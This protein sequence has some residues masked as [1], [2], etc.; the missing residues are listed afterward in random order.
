MEAV[1]QEPPYELTPPRPITVSGELIAYMT[2]ILL[3]FL[4]Y[5]ANLDVT[6]MSDV[7]ANRA[8]A[9]WQVVHP[10]TPGAQIPSESALTLWARAVPFSLF[11]GGEFSARIITVFGGLALVM[12]PLLFREQ[13]GRVQTFL[14]VVILAASP[15]LMTASRTGDPFIW[16]MLFTILTLWAFLRWWEKQQPADALLSGGFGAVMLFLSSGYGVIL[17]AIL[18]IAAAVTLW[19]SMLRAP[20][21]AGLLGNEFLDTIR[22]R[23]GLFPWPRVAAIALGVVVILATGWMLYPNG[24]NTLGELLGNAV[25]GIGQREADLPGAWP[26]LTLLFYEPLL[27]FFGLA[28]WFVLRRHNA[29][30]GDRFLIVWA[31]VAVVFS[32]FYANGQPAYALAVIFPLSALASGFAADLLLSRLSPYF[33]LD[34]LEAGDEQAEARHIWMVKWVLAALMLILLFMFVIH[35]QEIGRSLVTTPGP[36]SPLEILSTFLEPT[37]VRLRY[38]II[39]LV[40]TFMFILIGF[41][42]AAGFWGNRITLQG[43]AL[44]LFLF[45][46]LSGIGTGWNASV[47]FAQQ[48]SELWHPHAP[49][50]DIYLLRD[51]LN[52]I[53][54]RDTKGYPQLEI[55]VL[56]DNDTITPDGIIPW[57]LRDFTNTRYIT[58]FADVRREQIILLP[59]TLIDPDLG[60]AY[61]GQRFV[62]RHSWDINSVSL[63]DVWGWWAQRRI[64]QIEFPSAGVILWLRQDVF[65]GIPIQDRLN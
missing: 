59:E 14:W 50:P 37:Y 58:H 60:G 17:A 63:L 35:M 5:I 41:F 51:V 49:G 45:M 64:R 23:L 53:A 43:G 20:E 29:S 9:A 25:S 46:L 3:T 47:T 31:A 8:L 11:G 33:W 38:S 48:P 40:I 18:I 22:G 62:A 16:T 42:A 21:E 10:E 52:E 12:T 54:E 19:W 65:D 1:S 28:G 26:A 30:I 34:Y 61:V 36:L 15:V 4:L 44:G 27:I 55:A 57:L 2:V 39:W 56:V 6:P 32:L 13:I 7:E 24:L